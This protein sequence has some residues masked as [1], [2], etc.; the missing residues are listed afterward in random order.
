[1]NIDVKLHN[2]NLKTIRLLQ[3]FSQQKLAVLVGTSRQY[4]SY[5]EL[6]MS[7]SESMARRI[8]EVLEFRKYGLNWTSFYEKEHGE[9]K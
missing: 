5:I 3:G 4:I 6:G 9:E 8:A 1:M 7:P 2:V